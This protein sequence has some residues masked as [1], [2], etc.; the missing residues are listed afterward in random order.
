[1]EDMRPK[2]NKIDIGT[3]RQLCPVA[4][5]VAY[6]LRTTCR[7]NHDRLSEEDMRI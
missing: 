7:T 1:M 4:R 6:M 3:N 2:I 5:T